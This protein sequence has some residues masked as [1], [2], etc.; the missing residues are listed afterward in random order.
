[1]MN[2]EVDCN[3]TWEP[4]IDVEQAAEALYGKSTS[5]LRSYKYGELA[6]DRAERIITKVDVKQGNVFVP[7]LKRLVKQLAQFV[8]LCDNTLV[9]FTKLKPCFRAVRDEIEIL[10]LDELTGYSSDEIASAIF[11]LDDL[12]DI[13]LILAIS[14]IRHFK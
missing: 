11:E 14:K 4:E 8:T 2:I 10:K 7:N 12:T 9:S 13:P 1:M 3:N 5:L 6:K